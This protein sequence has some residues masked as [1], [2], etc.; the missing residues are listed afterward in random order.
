LEISARADFCG[1]RRTESIFRRR[2]IL[3]H[4]L[5]ATVTIE[6]KVFVNQQLTIETRE[7]LVLPTWFLV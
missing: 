3:R 1:A 2:R 6:L 7:K 5:E 4:Q